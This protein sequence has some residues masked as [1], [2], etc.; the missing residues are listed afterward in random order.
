MAYKQL[1]DH[2]WTPA[3]LSQW[4]RGRP[5]EPR[6]FCTGLLLK[7]FVFFDFLGFLGVKKKKKMRLLA[8]YVEGAARASD[9]K[10]E[11]TQR[12]RPPPTLLRRRLS[13]SLS[14]SDSD[15]FFL[16]ANY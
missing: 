3:R 15:S 10:A 5:L 6:T 8:C 14:L 9:L 16:I 1:L 7:N 13:L 4:L 12:T 11:I 2:I